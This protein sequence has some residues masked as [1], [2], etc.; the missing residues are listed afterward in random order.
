MECV[1]MSI[2]EDNACTVRESERV[3]EFRRQ[4]LEEAR[5]IARRINHERMTL[6]QSASNLPATE[7]LPD[8][9]GR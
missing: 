9:L 3:L 7:S 6:G 4:L 2:T 1:E 5:R 8:D